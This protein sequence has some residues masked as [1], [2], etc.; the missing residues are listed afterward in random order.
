VLQLGA[1][2]QPTKLAQIARSVEPFVGD[3]HLQRAVDAGIVVQILHH[4]F[5]RDFDIIIARPHR[6]H[7]DEADR[8]GQFIVDAM[9]QLAQEQVLLKARPDFDRI[10]NAA[11]TWDFAGYRRHA[12]TPCFDPVS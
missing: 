2:D 7:A 11:R 10:P 5:Q 3:G 9:G 6:G 1:A 4:A 12:L 8:R